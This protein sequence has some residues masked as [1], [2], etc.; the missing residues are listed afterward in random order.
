M[1]RDGT[2]EKFTLGADIRREASVAGARGRYAAA[3]DLYRRATMLRPDDHLAWRGLADVA[4]RTGDAVT[5]RTAWER[6]LA[7][8]PEGPEAGREARRRFDAAK[9]D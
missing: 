4:D 5:A 3:A 9:S 1:L 7:L 8:A 6:V 2:W